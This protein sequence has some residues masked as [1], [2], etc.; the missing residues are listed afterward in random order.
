MG[1]RSPGCT[2]Q[3][4]YRA[5][6]WGRGESTPTFEVARFCD[7]RKTHPPM[8]QIHEGG[9]LCGAIRDRTTADPIRTTVCHCT[10]CQRLTG[11]AFLV[12]P[13]FKAEAVAVS[14][15]D[16]KVY[17]RPSA[18]S[19]KRVSVNFCG[20]CGTSLFLSFERFPG[21]LGLFGGAFDDPNWFAR[22]PQ[23]SQHIFTRWARDDV[24]LPAGAALYT[25]HSLQLDGTANT[26]FTL[27]EPDT[28]GRV[29]RS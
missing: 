24:V 13:I 16:P 2:I 23:D 15:E 7:G 12:E 25:D 18:G 6:P 9:C 21:Y 20:R 8:T 28:A 10:F 14:G 11:S 26:P 1:R 27:T 19:G 3:E 22:D 17:E 4:L 5:R 29:R